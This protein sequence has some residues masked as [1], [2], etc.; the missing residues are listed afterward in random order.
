MDFCDGVKAILKY[1]KCLKARI[2]TFT[3]DNFKFN[4][5]TTPMILASIKNNYD[6]LHILFDNGHKILVMENLT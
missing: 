1:H 3:D 5:G 6:M 4:I 2:N